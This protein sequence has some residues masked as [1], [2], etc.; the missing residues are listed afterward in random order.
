VSDDVAEQLAKLEQHPDYEAAVRNAPK[1]ST[2]A[3][4]VLGIALTVGGG[5]LGVVAPTSTVRTIG[6]CL[7]LAG[8]ACLAVAVFFAATPLERV[9]AMVA[10]E[11]I[12]G[13]RVGQPKSE[14]K[15]Y[16]ILER[17]DGEKREY[18]ANRELAQQL[19]EGHAG[20]AYLKAGFLLAFRRLS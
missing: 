16:V 15:H 6:W 1:S 17:I 11:R 9:L 19:E 3:M 12:R 4:I 2:A 7:S 8:V 10:D 18:R 13:D 5:I 14:R 20:V